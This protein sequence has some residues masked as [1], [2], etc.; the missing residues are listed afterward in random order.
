MKKIQMLLFSF[1]LLSQVGY[2]QSGTHREH[3]MPKK[4]ATFDDIL[5]SKALDLSGYIPFYKE[6]VPTFTSV[7]Y[8]Y[9]SKYNNAACMVY[10]RK[11]GSQK[12]RDAFKLVTDKTFFNYSG[13]IVDLNEGSNQ[14][15][16]R[17]IAT[18]LPEEIL[19]SNDQFKVLD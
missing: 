14:L 1:L 11:L 16:I 8:Y 7:S 3:P 9:P 13:S 10:Y 12:W 4:I 18:F 2:M 19:I 6:L 15:I 17:G 5:N